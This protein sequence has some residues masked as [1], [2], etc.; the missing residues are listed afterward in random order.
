[1]FV[2]VFSSDILLYLEVHADHNDLYTSN[3][4]NY[5]FDALNIGSTSDDKTK[6]TGSNYSD[7]ER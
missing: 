7:Q 5:L 1:M 4:F 6:N 2:I 3:R